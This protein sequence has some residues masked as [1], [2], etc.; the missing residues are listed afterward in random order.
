LPCCHAFV[1]FFIVIRSYNVEHA[2]MNEAALKRRVGELIRAITSSPFLGEV[3]KAAPQG[4]YRP[5]GSSQGDALEACLD[6]LQLQ[7]K[8]LLF[9]LEA[10][11]RENRYLRQMLENRHKRDL[12]DLKGDG[13][14]LA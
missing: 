8:Y 4:V 9:D 6:Q 5:E 13:P 11:R 1:C 12:D 3:L 14:D 2:A 7:V 10:T